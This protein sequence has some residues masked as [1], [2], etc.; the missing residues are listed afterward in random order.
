[1]PFEEALG[2]DG[3]LLDA[4]AQPPAGRRPEAA[5]E[6]LRADA[7]P[8]AQAPTRQPAVSS[9]ATAPAAAPAAAATAPPDGRPRY[10]LLTGP[11]DAAFCRRVSEALDEGYV[12]HGSPTLAM[13]G[14]DTLAAQAVVWPHPTPSAPPDQPDAAASMGSEE[15]LPRADDLP[16]RTNEAPVIL[17]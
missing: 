2:A 1:M 11:D 13:R 15:I 3:L 17:K 8:P 10:Q 9:T 12:L 5:V 14:L 7:S 16:T 4:E 6:G